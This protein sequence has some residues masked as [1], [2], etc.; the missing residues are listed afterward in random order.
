MHKSLTLLLILFLIAGLQAQTQ[1]SG[2][3]DSETW[4]QAGSPYQVVGDI[5]V[6]QLTIEPGTTIE[7]TGNYSFEITG[8]LDAQGTAT[9]SII[10]K[11]SASNTSGWKGIYFNSASSQC[12]LAYTRIS[13]AS[14]SYALKVYN[15]SLEFSQLAVKNNAATGILINNASL[16]LTHSFVQFNQNYGINV[17]KDGDA[18]LIAC[19]VTNNQDNGLH[20]NQGSLTLKNSVVAHNVNEGVLLAATDDALTALNTVIAY[21]QK[22]G[23]VGVGATV[24]ISNSIVYFNNALNQIY[25]ASGTTTVTYS[26]VQDQDFGSTN[27]M[28]DPQFDNVSTRF[29]L[30]ASS[31]AIDAGDPSDDQN[32]IYFPPSLGSVRN[33]MGAYGGP[34]ARKWYRPLFVQPDTL[35]FGDVSLGDSL[36]SSVLLK[37]YADES[38][39]VDALALSGDDAAQFRIESLALPATI[40]MADS[41][42]VP[43]TFKPASARLVPFEA[44]LN[45]TSSVEN[46]RVE[47]E[48]R[49]VVADILVLPSELTFDPTPVGSSDSLQVKIF[50]SGTDTL[51]IDSVQTLSPAFGYRLSAQKLAPQSDTVIFLTV[52][53]APDTIADYQSAVKIFCNDPDESPVSVTVQGSGLAPI[54]QVYPL[55]AQFDS[56]RVFRDS[57]FTLLLSNPGN[58]PLTIDS[59]ELLHKNPVF[60]LQTSPP[61]HLEG[62]ANHVPLPI[63]FEAD[64]SGNFSDTLR[65]VS[66]DPFKPVRLIPLLATATAAYIHAQ[67]KQIDF[68]TLIAP[69]DTVL[70][71]TVRNSGNVTLHI[72]RIDL[73]GQDA[74]SFRW[75]IQEGK[76]SVQPQNDSL[77]I[78]LHCAPVRSGMLKAQLNIVSDDPR[79]DS[80]RVPLQAKVKAAEMVILPDTVNFPPT[81]IFNEATRQVKI[82]NRGDSNLQIDSIQ[83]SL[84]NGEDLHFPQLQFPQKI[85][86]QT[87]TLNFTIR[88]NP[89]ATGVQSA[90]LRF[91]SNDP[92][93]NPRQLTVKANAV[94]PVL[95]VLTDSLNFG[96]VSAY[97]K[98]TAKI[99]IVSQGSAPA[100]I[101]SVQI[102]NDP[103]HAFH[104]PTFSLPLSVAV[105]DSLV[106]P[107]TFSPQEN[108]TFASQ[109]KIQWNDPYQKEIS[110]PLSAVADTAFLQAPLTL[111]FGKHAIH[112]INKKSLAIH[113]DS[114][115]PLTIDS[116]RITGADAAQFQLDV[117]GLNFTLQPT[118]TVLNIPVEYVPHALGV[119]SARLEL[120]SLDLKHRVVQVSL[121]G[122]ALASASAPLLISDLKDSVDFGAVFV[123]ENK[124]RTCYLTNVGNAPLR[125]DSLEL[126]GEQTADFALINPPQGV[127]IAADDTLKTFRLQFKPQQVGNCSARLAIFSNDGNSPLI[128]ILN[129]EGEIDPTPATIVPSFDTL[130]AVAGKRF[131]VSIQAYDDNTTINRAEAFFKQGGETAFSQLVMKKAADRLWQADIDSDR[132]TMRGLALYFKVYHGG[133]VTEYPQKGAQHPLT[134]NVRVP[135]TNLP[136]RI[137]PQKYYMISLPV[138]TNGQT[139]K[140]LFGDE[141]GAY[142]PAKYRF[143]DWDAVRKE[144]IELSEMKTELSVGKAVYLVTADSVNLSVRNAISVSSGQPFELHLSKGWNMIGD[145]FAFPVNWQTVSGQN[146]LTLFYFNGSA[147]EMA[148]N[149]EPFKGYAV[150]APY[151]LTLKVPPASASSVMAKPLA[152]AIHIRGLQ[153]TARSGNYYDA[154]NFA[155]I[156]P[157]TQAENRISDIPEPPVIGT[158]VSLY[159]TR[160]GNKGQKLTADFRPEGQE[161]YRFDVTIKANTGRP[162]CLTVLNDS[163]PQDYDWCLIAPQRGVRYREFP[164]TLYHDHATLQ[165]L[166][167]KKNFLNAQL[168]A[169]RLLPHQFRMHPNYPNPF[170]STTKIQVDLPDADWLTVTVYDIRGRRIKTLSDN[171]L[172]DA[173]YYTFKWDGTNTG[174]LPVA[175]GIYFIHLQG[176]KFRAD[177][178]IILQK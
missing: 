70:K 50:N 16:Q 153:L 44:R 173:G 82:V 61:L 64:T 151:A 101:T 71:L 104:I 132:V 158:Y 86:P 159:F 63:Y 29:N 133:S 81:I 27:L 177:Q 51:R 37:N 120:Y 41:L 124:I 99:V 116:L 39:T 178:K 40:P 42:R 167:G 172:F 142:D 149:L 174:G 135:K 131:A 164:V 138:N 118:D 9:D 141:L 65:L 129:G 89:K 87:D 91:Y 90:Q 15:C 75:Q 35:Q 52:Y 165:L 76:Y 168:A 113:N 38:L 48:G 94:A 152:R 170:N 4:N 30:S 66:T 46:R 169:L 59:L 140:D 5:T 43:L 176:K 69:V 108:G 33:D 62:G 171:R 58:A 136:Y 19:T 127:Q 106:I 7:F 1:V 111:D 109:L 23:I 121:S 115:V 137:L 3:I 74:P 72:K 85:R 73:T 100:E 13:D 157:K 148:S 14:G 57:I 80:L 2:V 11:A 18:T 68:Q 150:K 117:S 119:H 128:L 147:W 143:F 32:D 56:V 54:L 95:H 10:F 122:I 112:S 77:H 84:M 130:Q 17:I 25:N 21:N 12:V 78:L 55:Q 22:E 110:I 31:P 107:V 146:D 155:G 139:L 97:R 93:V 8:N 162:I 144:F 163:L 156:L 79:F 67:P 24:A 175:S 47:L 166:V 83:I 126:T 6:L 103:E 145:P 88:F 96:A 154:I 20:T 114:R 26:D 102:V 92:F 123:N 49:G 98:P 60:S 36:M 53:F 45:I 105:H 134:V 161:G 28:V 34:L 160:K 125:I